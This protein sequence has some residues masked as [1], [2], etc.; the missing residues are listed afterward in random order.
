[1]KF[2]ELLEELIAKFPKAPKMEDSPYF[3]ITRT[4]TKNPAMLILYPRSALSK[5]DKL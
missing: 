3:H 2:D 1:M 5:I 4:F